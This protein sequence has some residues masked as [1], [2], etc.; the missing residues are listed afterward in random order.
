MGYLSRRSPITNSRTEAPLAQC[1]PRLIGESQL[2][3]CPIHTP[4]DTSA[5]TVQPTAQCVQI[6]FRMVAPA[7][8]GPA[9]GASAFRT[10]VSGRGPGAGG[11]GLAFGPSDQH[12]APPYLELG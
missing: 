12:G 1:E 6:P 9:A 5:V 11:L 3:S 10:L 2:G 4:L 7:V 8:S